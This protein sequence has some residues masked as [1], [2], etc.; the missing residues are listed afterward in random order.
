MGLFRKSIPPLGQAGV[1][2][3]PEGPIIG[4][5][6]NV[7]P[8]PTPE[9]QALPRELWD[10]L[11]PGAPRAGRHRGPWHGPCPHF[12]PRTPFLRRGPPRIKFDSRRFFRPAH[13][14]KGQFPFPIGSNQKKIPDSLKRSLQTGLV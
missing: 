12:S 10:L 7:D 9:P 4:W 3:P 8:P 6:G 1:G 13:K 2:P 11:L 5:L 14:G